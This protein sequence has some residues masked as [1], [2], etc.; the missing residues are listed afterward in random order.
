MRSATPLRRKTVVAL[1][2]AVTV[3][4]G[5]GFSPAASA[6]APE[7]VSA[8]T[9]F[10]YKDSYGQERNKSV[11]VH[12][13]KRLFEDGDLSV[14]DRYIR[15]DYI[16]HNP[17]AADGTEPLKEFAR[18]VLPQFPDLK[19][20]V[21]RVMAQGDMVLVHSNVVFTPGTRG[22][23][24]IDMY[25]FDKQGMIVEHWDTLQDV[26]ATSVNGNDMFGTVSSPRTNNPGP[27][28]LTAS[29]QRIATG[30]FDRLMADKDPGA[31][32]Y[33]APEYHQHNPTIPSGSAGLREQ[34]ASFFEQFP[35]LIVERRSVVTEGDLVAIHAHYRLNA[36]DR[37]ASVFDIFRVRNGK[38][39]EHWD[40][41]QEVPETS[42]ND[43]TMF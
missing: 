34:F 37:G 16:Q 15:P 39:V 13:L 11:S 24:V 18:T 22:Q 14:V 10:G 5:A 29:S 27:S 19:Y 31:V 36:S 30:Y 9:N 26:P 17:N 43:N 38:I 32:E 41:S 20:D 23:A 2:T 3:G 21:K 4:A 33:L 8:V 12:V 28:L 7:S 6:S 35:D 40:V 42:A 1:L 25:R